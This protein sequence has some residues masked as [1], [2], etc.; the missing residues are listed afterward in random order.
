MGFLQIQF[1]NLLEIL[2]IIASSQSSL[3]ATPPNFPIAKPH[4]TDR[5]GSLSIP[6]PFGTAPGCYQSYSFFVTCNDSFNPP[7]AFM[8]NSA[9]EITDISLDGQLRTLQFIARDCYS[10][11]GTKISSN[12]PWIS[13]PRSLTINYTANKF[14]IIGCNIRGF[15]PGRSLNRNYTTGCVAMCDAKDD[16]MEGSCTGLGCCQTCIPKQAETAILSLLSIKNHT[17]VWG[18][19]NCSYAFLAEESAFTF[20]SENL[21]NL[22]NV[23]KLPMVVD[24][25]MGNETCEEAKGDASSYA[26]KSDNSKCYKPDNGYGYRCSCLEGYQGNPYF[27]DGCRD[28]NE[29]ED[30]HLNICETRCVNKIGDFHC[31]CPKGY[32]GDGRKDGRGCIREE[33]RAS[34]LLAGLLAG[35]GLFLIMAISFWSYK[36]LKKRRSNQLKQAFLKRNVGLLLQQQIS[37]HDSILDN[38]KVFTSR[39]LERATDK[40]NES[41]ILGRG[42]Q[43][44]VYKG[45]LTDG[46]IVAVKK[47]KRVNE[48]QLVE[49]INE[50]A[51]LSQINHRNVVKLLGCCLETEVPLLVYEF[52]PNGTLYELIHDDTTGFLFSWDVRLRIAAEIAN[53]LAYLH[54][55]TSIPIYHRD[56]KSNNILLDEKYRAKLSDFGISRSVAIDQTHLT[57]KVKGTF[58]YFDPEYFQTGKFTEKSDVYSFGVVLV[59]LLTGEKLISNSVTEEEEE[60]EERG[61]IMRFLMTMKENCLKTILDPRIVEQDVKEEHLAVANLSKRC[62]NL[63]GR[64]RPTIREVAMALESIRTSDNPLSVESKMHDLSYSETCTVESRMQDLSYSETDSLVLNRVETASSSWTL[65]ND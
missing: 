17:S 50:V 59:E 52:I 5:C 63:N 10:H 61:L 51:I 14:T 24:W 21:T 46:R 19:N 25:A 7:R 8:Q 28:V 55:A 34:K 48:A 38:M 54:Y 41:R 44:T 65:N 1:L 16:L 13:L 29:C 12:R 42:G 53:A 45:M 27:I 49:F 26:C 6:Y 4:C 3:S 9:I 60:D 15:I 35:L 62:L 20:S 57:T 2:V 37:A 23:K 18:F 11:N 64:K 30:P 47:S 39:E 32:H 43:G 40:F 56:M 31:A 22:G 33:S 58:G 36:I